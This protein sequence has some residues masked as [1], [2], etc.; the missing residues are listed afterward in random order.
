MLSPLFLTHYTLIIHFPS[1]AIGF[2]LSLVL[3]LLRLSTWSIFSLY[4]LL[5]PNSDNDY[6][7][8]LMHLTA[9]ASF[10]IFSAYD[11]PTL[12]CSSCPPH[13]LHYRSSFS[14]Y[15]MTWHHSRISAPRWQL[16][17]IAV[18]PEERHNVYNAPE[19]QA[20]V[21]RMKQLMENYKRRLRP[22]RRARKEPRGNARNFGGVETPGWCQ[23]GTAR[24]T[25]TTT[26]S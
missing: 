8:L 12:A 1:S 6:S 11:M 16:F 5:T 4:L 25:S 2:D 23:L 21:S 18:D 14:I 26:R 19:N 7:I 10:C 17:N 24:P 15:S 13:K 3:N 22:F 9:T 20:I